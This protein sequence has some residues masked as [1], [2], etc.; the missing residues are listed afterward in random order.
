MKQ[1]M[2]GRPVLIS[3]KIAANHKLSFV[4]ITREAGLNFRHDA[5]ESGHYPTPQ[6]MGLG[7]ASFDCD[8]DGRLDVYL[9]DGG[10]LKTDRE[11]E[12]SSGPR[13]TP[14]RLFHQRADGTFADITASWGLT[15][16]GYGMGK[17]VGDIDNDGG[18]D[19]YLTNYGA[20][21]LFR[22]NGDCTG[23]DITESA[24]LDVRIFRRL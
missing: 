12:H 6:I 21:R 10:P 8:V 3:P 14:G 9:V 1:V 23:T 18:L 15:N 22:N 4:E 7:A 2:E 24:V 16:A 17:A 11:N 20:D 5:G 19:L 13:S